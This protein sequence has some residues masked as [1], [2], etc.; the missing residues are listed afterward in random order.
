M[1]CHG[2]EV[3]ETEAGM[4]AEDPSSKGL[5]LA[6]DASKRGRWHYSVNTWEEPA[7]DNTG[8]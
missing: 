4:E 1:A 5:I 6:S 2:I 8:S 3:T 7:C